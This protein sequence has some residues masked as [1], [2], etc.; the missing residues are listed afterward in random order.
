MVQGLVILGTGAVPCT[1]FA[2][3]RRI[4]VTPLRDGALEPRSCGELQDAILSANKRQLRSN[5]ELTDWE[6]PL[7]R[8][9]RASSLLGWY[10]EPSHTSRSR[11]RLPKGPA[12]L[13]NLLRQNVGTT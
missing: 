5:S 8:R 12:L 4:V 1:D 3:K 10:H 9:V 6:L 13:R 7:L 11:T 2:Q